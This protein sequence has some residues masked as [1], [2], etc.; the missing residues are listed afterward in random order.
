MCVVF[1]FECGELFNNP[2]ISA[3]GGNEATVGAEL[4]VA[5]IGADCSVQRGNSIKHITTLL[6]KRA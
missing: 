5:R 3:D 4:C 2:V 1:V 6:K